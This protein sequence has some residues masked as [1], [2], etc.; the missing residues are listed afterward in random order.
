[1]TFICL[2]N[3]KVNRRWFWVCQGQPGSGAI[4]VPSQ[5]FFLNTVLP[6]CIDYSVTSRKDFTAPD[7]IRDCKKA[8]RW[9]RKNADAFGWDPDRIGVYGASAGGHIAAMLG[10]TSGGAVSGLEGEIDSDTTSSDMQAVCAVRGVY[11]LEVVSSQR[12]RE[13]YS[14]LHEV[15]EKYLG[16]SVE[17]KPELAKK[18]SPSNNISNKCPPVLLI[19]T[20]PC[21]TIPVADTIDFYQK[22]KAADIDATIRILCNSENDPKWLSDSTQNIVANFFRRKLTTP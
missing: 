7:N 16:G 1:M 10:V 15:T 20:D 17:E 13:H 18:L 8:V 5:P 22:L 2:L 4:K 21:N 12:I 3:W 14:R 9:L 19:S 11:D 6:W